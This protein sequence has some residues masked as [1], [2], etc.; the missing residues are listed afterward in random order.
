M[1]AVTAALWRG[2]ACARVGL[3]VTR[4]LTPSS[5]LRSPLQ[6]EDSA[7]QSNIFAVEPK[8]YVQGS[9][10]DTTDTAVSNK[11]VATGAAMTLVLMLL[12]AKF[13][14]GT[15]YSYENPQALSEYVRMFKQ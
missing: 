8:T 14:G 2:P 15:D 12:V 3:E 4:L 9:D 13:S 7:G 6:S 10:A 5:S 1:R 11:Y